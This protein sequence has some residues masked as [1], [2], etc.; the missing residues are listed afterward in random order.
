MYPYRVI[1]ISMGVG[2]QTYTNTYRKDIFKHNEPEF[3]RQMKELEWQGI[4]EQE[5]GE[6]E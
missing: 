1:G 2:T 6:N 5:F 3:Q 4:E